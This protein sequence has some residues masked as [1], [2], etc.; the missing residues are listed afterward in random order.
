[1][2][3]RGPAPT[4]TAI[5]ANR[6]SWRAKINKDEP[7][8]TGV[9]ELPGGVEL[10]ERALAMWTQLTGDLSA[11]G[12]ATAIDANALSR[13][14]MIWDRWLRASVAQDE[15]RMLTLSDALSKLEAQFGMTPSARTRIK[16]ETPKRE[17]GAAAFFTKKF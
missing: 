11:A 6:G 16:T 17:T 13:Y 9:P 4:P 3:T 12:I 15:K 10:S 5:L 2:G 14:C 1:M 7:K 8:P